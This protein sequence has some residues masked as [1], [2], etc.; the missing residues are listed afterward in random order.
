M[1]RGSRKPGRT[2]RCLICSRNECGTNRQRKSYIAAG[3]VRDEDGMYYGAFS[4]KNSHKVRRLR[5]K[6]AWKNEEF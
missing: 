6:L 4:K 2:C 1:S 3:I 5:E